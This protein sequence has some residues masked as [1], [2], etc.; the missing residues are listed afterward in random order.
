MHVPYKGS[1]PAMQDVIG[2]QVP[3]MFDTSVV[4][5]P[6]IERAGKVRSPS[7]RQT[8]AAQLPNR[9]RWRESGVAGCDRLVPGRPSLLRPVPGPDPDVCK[10]RWEKILKS[11]EIV[12][13]D[14]GKIGYG[15]PDARAVRCIPGSRE[16]A[17]WASVIKDRQHQD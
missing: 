13:T 14:Q 11:P 3:M 15:S 2:G 17:K 9:R 4:A 1:A 12:G 5:S 8:H 7:P 6:F 10:L 16:I